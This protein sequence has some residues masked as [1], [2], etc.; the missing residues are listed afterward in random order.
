MATVF[1][2]VGVRPTTIERDGRSVTLLGAPVA[3]VPFALDTGPDVVEERASRGH[4]VS[5]TTTTTTT[6]TST[7]APP[8]TLPTPPVTARPV[9]RTTTRP[10]PAPPA[11][12]QAAEVDGLPRT[13]RRIGGCESNGAPDA[14]LDFTAAN[15]YSTASGAWQDL[16]SSWGTWARRF[17]DVIIQDQHDDPTAYGRAMYAPP[18][19]QTAVNLHVYLEDGT[20]AWSPSRGCWA[21]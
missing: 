7:T 9:T 19:I 21:G 15:P 1:A 18:A 5:T 6:T 12:V 4:T 16:D 17:R 3:V 10:A 14:P 13:F 8:T 2:L 20:G 11:M